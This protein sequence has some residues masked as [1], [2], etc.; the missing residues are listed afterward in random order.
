MMGVEGRRVRKRG[1]E[2]MKAKVCKRERE[3]EGRTP[4]FWL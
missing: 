4:R 2:M 1:N 3:R